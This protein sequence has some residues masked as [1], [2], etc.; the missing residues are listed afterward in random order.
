MRAK[1]VERGTIKKEYEFSSVFSEIPWEDFVD[2]MVFTGR[3]KKGEQTSTRSITLEAKELRLAEI[4]KE[5]SPNNFQTISDVI[6]DA[7]SKGLKV[8]YE[9]LVRRKGKIKLRADATF[10]ELV[11]IDEEL[12]YISHV[13]MVEKRITTILQECKKNIAGK[14]IEWGMETI[15][16]LIDTADRDF[17]KRGVKEY[18]DSMLNKHNTVETMLFN[19][20]EYKKTGNGL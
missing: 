2:R 4:I 10:N 12:A 7:I 14:N 15:N 3:V 17:P 9:I 6:R 13:E 5:S 8:D 1:A 18:F 20:R 19:I 11:M 16:H